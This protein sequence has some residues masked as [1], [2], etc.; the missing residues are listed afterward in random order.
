MPLI[1]GWSLSNWPV[2][3]F[4]PPWWRQQWR[5]RWQKLRNGGLLSPASHLECMFFT[6][7]ASEA[8][9]CTQLCPPG[10]KPAWAS[11][12]LKAPVEMNEKATDAR[13]CCRAYKLV[14]LRL[15]CVFNRGRCEFPVLFLC[16]PEILRPPLSQFHCG[17]ALIF[18][19]W[20]DIFT[21][22]I[23]ICTV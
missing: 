16:E 7:P 11:A 9:V 13:V 14:L 5:R 15:S 22:L 19:N 20:F 1:W 2:A 10:Y 3:H 12:T 21:P 8:H 23:S 4:K 18:G 6:W 17:R